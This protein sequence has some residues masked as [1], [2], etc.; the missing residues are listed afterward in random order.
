M[1]DPDTAA[2]MFPL[3]HGPLADIKEVAA[4]CEE[5]GIDVA[6]GSEA[7]DKP[8]CTPKFQLLAR[9]EDAPRVEA[10]LRERWTKGL[11]A[12]GLSPVAYEDL[13]EGEPPC[14]ACGTA[15]PLVGGACSD[16]GLQLE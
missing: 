2:E 12:D 16:C 3:L 11:E 15:A 1:N 13:G 8:N 14:P 4:L 5:A 10:L 7:C 6:L 9:K